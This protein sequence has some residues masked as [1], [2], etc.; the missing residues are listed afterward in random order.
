[1]DRLI[2]AAAT[3][4]GVTEWTRPI[5]RRRGGQS[6]AFWP[7]GAACVAIPSARGNYRANRV[8][9]T[10]A[11]PPVSHMPQHQ[12]L[13]NAEVVEA[14]LMIF[15]STIE[16]MGIMRPGLVAETLNVAYA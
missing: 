11:A 8:R 4:Q 9:C 12:T 13:K 6:S 2:G 10:V 16:V 1:V 5:E 14:G 7:H 15:E 3:A